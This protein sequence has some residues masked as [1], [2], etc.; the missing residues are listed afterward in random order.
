MGSLEFAPPYPCCG[1][2]TFHSGGPKC[3]AYRSEVESPAPRPAFIASPFRFP[4]RTRLTTK[5]S[6][7]GWLPQI[8]LGHGFRAIRVMYGLTLR[9]ISAGWQISDVE[10]GE[11]ERGH[12][13]F[14]TP[15]DMQAALSQLWLWAVEKNPGIAR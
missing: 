1:N 5:T 10:S 9:E 13:H 6:T 15:A 11:L 3:D 2:L 7:D 12:R 8:E 14:A 4:W